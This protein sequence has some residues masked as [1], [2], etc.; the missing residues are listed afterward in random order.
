MITKS[1]FF[2]IV[3]FTFPFSL[4]AQTSLNIGFQVYPAGFVPT[5]QGEL[6]LN[7]DLRIFGRIGYNFTDRNDWGEHDE[8]EGSGVG[9]GFGFKT[10]NI[11]FNKVSLHAATDF[12]FM[13]IDWTTYIPCEPASTS[14]GRGQLVESEIYGVSEIIVLQPVIGINYRLPTFNRL[15]IEPGISF[16]YEINIHTEGEDVGDGPI[17]LGGI[18]IG[19]LFKAR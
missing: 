7:S 14:C 19:Y 4:L 11:L 1:A 16:G 2:A 10:S 8:E 6:N 18:Q 15:I 12:W 17:L 9:F 13:D 5:L 3:L